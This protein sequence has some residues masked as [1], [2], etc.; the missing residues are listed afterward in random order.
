MPGIAKDHVTATIIDLV[1]GKKIVFS[2]PLLELPRWLE[3]HPKR[4]V[5]DEL[6]VKRKFP[7][8]KSL[9]SKGKRVYKYKE[10]YY[11]V[12]ELI[13]IAKSL[14]NDLTYG[15]VRMRL[16]YLASDYRS[17]I[18]T[19]EDALTLPPIKRKAYKGT[20]YDLDRIVQLAQ[21]EGIKLSKSTVYQ[22]LKRG[23]SIY[24]TV[25]TPV[26][27][28]VGKESKEVKDEHYFHHT[29]IRKMLPTEDF[30]DYF[31]KSE[32]NNKKEEYTIKTKII[33]LSITMVCTLVMI[34]GLILAPF[35]HK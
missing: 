28:H 23:W 11:S 10:R 1:N 33:I 15:E 9:I 26:Q 35:F 25:H 4:L 27:Y 22:R 31:R 29:N 18:E 34:G 16:E 2:V 3:A 13:E 8:G 30:R 5:S 17:D 12:S 7:K 32:I 6:G 21:N 24:K 14:G 19:M 20:I